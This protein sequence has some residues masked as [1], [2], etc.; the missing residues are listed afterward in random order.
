MKV[1]CLYSNSY[2]GGTEA[3]LRN[4]LPFI[5][6]TPGIRVTFHD[7]YSRPSVN[8]KFEDLGLPIWRTG[9]TEDTS[10]LS[11]H[12]GFRRKLDV[13][14]AIPRHL[15]I[16]LR[17]RPALCECDVLYVHG[18][19]DLAL[20]QAARLASTQ[21]SRPIVWHCHGLGDDQRPPML[22]ALAN[23][24]ARVIAIS[25]DVRNHLV[26]IGVRSSIVRAV[27]NAVDYRRIEEAALRSPTQPLPRIGTRR[28]VLLCPAAIRADKGIHLAIEALSGLPR[29]V[30][31]WVTGD[32]S[33]PAASDYLHSLLSL[34]ERVGVRERVFFL[35][36]RTDLPAVMSV[37]HVIC[38]PSIVREGFALV[39][40][41]AMALGKAV[42]ASS[43]GA[44][45][46]VVRDGESG[47]TFDPDRPGDLAR[48]LS[49]LLADSAL[50]ASLGAAGR[51][52]VMLRFTYDRWASEV[53]A[54]LRAAASL[55]ESTGAAFRS[56]NGQAEINSGACRQVETKSR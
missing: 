7:L 10:I 50:A 9:R 5:N 56:G 21:P 43:R 3:V 39:A 15:Q 51:R 55:G 18:Y 29:D 37:A 28:I 12:S 54:Q 2:G 52:S 30:D 31:V 42:V 22:P 32:T 26:A 36:V 48:K 40:A 20:C 24:C 14:A 11:F 33:D 49:V 1:L 16:A 41:E 38:V 45:P 8:R 44:L 19:K 23:R 34:A 27:Y 17:L 35:G 6:G 53:I 47:L 46:E 13:A 25:E 4:G